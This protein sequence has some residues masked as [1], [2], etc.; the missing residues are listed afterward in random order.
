MAVPDFSGFWVRVGNL[1]FDPIL[2][3]DEGKPVSR[4]KLNRP[5]S[6]KFTDI[7]N[8]ASRDTPRDSR[9]FGERRRTF[10]PER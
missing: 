9:A 7:E 3:D 2:D 6:R 1:W 10:S 4:L 5:P 8:S